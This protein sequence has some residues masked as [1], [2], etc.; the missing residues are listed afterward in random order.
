MQTGAISALSN[1]CLPDSLKNFGAYA[2]AF[3]LLAIFLTHFVQV[4]AVQTMSRI[5][6]KRDD[7]HH[8]QPAQGNEKERSSSAFTT[9]V[10]D[11]N[12]QEKAQQQDPNSHVLIMQQKENDTLAEC[13][14]EPKSVDAHHD[15]SHG[16][17]LIHSTSVTVYLLEFGIAL[18]SIIIGV[19][20]GIARE[21]FTILL[22]AI[23]FHQFF[24]GIAL[25]SI[26]LE[27]ELKKKYLAWLMVFFCK[28][29]NFLR[30]QEEGL[31]LR[32]NL[33]LTCINPID[34]IS[35]S[36][37]IAIGIG[38][39]MSSYNENDASALAAIGILDALAA[40]ILIYDGLVNMIAPHFYRSGF[41]AAPVWS[42]SLQFVFLWLGAIAMAVIGIWA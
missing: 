27:A 32:S 37:G 35:T 13:Q 14:K 2:G 26:I 31:V 11:N 10:N 19:T 24:E 17:L 25:S 20:L 42:Q 12:S 22:I 38:A 9:V 30:D 36:I 23:C 7:H 21:D 29:F 28:F 8:H 15:H 40:G 34:S 5:V 39:A 4:V 18:H 16:G 41:T 33:F 6:K 3:A 1:P